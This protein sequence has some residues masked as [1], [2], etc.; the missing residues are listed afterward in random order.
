[1]AATVRGSP[2]ARSVVRYGRQDLAVSIPEGGTTR[3]VLEG[4][5]LR[6]E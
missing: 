3:I 4:E 1:M 2:G 6:A 5:S